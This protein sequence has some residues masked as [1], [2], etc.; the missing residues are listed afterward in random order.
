MTAARSPKSAARQRVERQLER[1]AELPADAT[2]ASLVPR[3]EDPN[4]LTIRIGR[5]AVGPVHAQDA[6]TLG[7][8]PESP[9]DADLRSRLAEALA[10]EAARADALR[11][12]RARA[13]AKHDLIRRLCRKGHERAHAAA[14]AERLERVGLIDDE[15]LAR[16]RAEQLAAANRLGPR[17]AESR[18]RT[19][20]IDAPTSARAVTGAY[21]DVDLLDQAAEAARKRLRSMGSRLDPETRTRRLFGFLARRGYDHEICR[22]AIARALAPPPPEEAP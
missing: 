5:F 6:E 16:D 9:L 3:D 22:L 11:M 19:M 7:L 10:R 1:L 4:R 15:A 21:E 8:A 12:L 17:A 2:I 13:R 14:A 20:G 18:L